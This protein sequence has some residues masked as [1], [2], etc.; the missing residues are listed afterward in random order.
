MSEDR[1]ARIM[2]AYDA[3]AERGDDLIAAILAAVPNT[4][5]EEIVA[6]LRWSADKAIAEA[7]QLDR[8]RKAK[9]GAP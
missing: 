5:R 2:A 4:S 7:G 8:Y 6:A 1:F 9:F 3:A